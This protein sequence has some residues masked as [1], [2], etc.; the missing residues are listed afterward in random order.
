MVM[1]Q[2]ERVYRRDWPMNCYLNL[3]P[4]ELL[5]PIF[6]DVLKYHINTS[7]FWR[8][9][10]IF[11]E[12]DLEPLYFGRIYGGD[13]DDHLKG[14]RYNVDKQ[15]PPLELALIPERGLYHQ[16]FYMRMQRCVL[17]LR[18]SLS[19]DWSEAFSVLYENWEESH[20]SLVADEKA[21]EEFWSTIPNDIAWTG[22][23]NP[24]EHDDRWPSMWLCVADKLRSPRRW[25]WEYPSLKFLSPLM[26]SGCRPMKLYILGKDMTDEYWF[27]DEIDLHTGPKA[28]IAIDQFFQDATTF[29]PDQIDNLTIQFDEIYGNGWRHARFK[30]QYSHIRQALGGFLA[31]L[32]VTK[33]TLR[34]ICSREEVYEVSK[35]DSQAGYRGDFA[36]GIGL[37]LRCIVC[38]FRF[39]SLPFPL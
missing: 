35:G 19:F 4:Y 34:E 30:S 32:H 3:L 15:L 18:P 37:S 13:Y 5:H 1:D 36:D 9:G 31:R 25:H 28:F 27:G 20:K 6:E 14:L 8:N 29:L 33:V 21:E 26:R 2:V 10:H 12:D 17:V 22:G 16:F 7:T 39:L 11:I 23:P 24:E 38:T